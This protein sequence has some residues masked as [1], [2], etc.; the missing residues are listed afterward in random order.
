M[1]ENLLELLKL[2]NKYYED[3]C[4]N[5]NK[6]KNYEFIVGQVPIIISAPHAVMQVRNGKVKV[7][8]YLTGPIT[9]YLC[10]NTRC[11]GI[12]RTFCNND[13]PNHDKKGLGFEYKRD[14]STYITLQSI[15]LLID[16]HGCKDS[17]EYDFQIGTNNG[18]NLTEDKKI[19]ELVIFSLK[20]IGKVVVDK[21]FKAD[22]EGNI[23]KYI[24]YNL[25][26]PCTQIEITAKYRKEPDSINSLIENLK[27]MIK[28]I[29]R[30]MYEN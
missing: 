1:E 7:A 11:H 15:Q 21:E 4:N 8:D 27:E 23:S 16:L 18:L 26:I 28:E 14:L 19:L 5:E 20:K 29:N 3:N 9:E 25:N 30:Y 12:V 22:K 24:S 10:R 2:N 17:E 13:D 6:E